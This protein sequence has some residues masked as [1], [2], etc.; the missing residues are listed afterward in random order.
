MGDFPEIGDA[1]ETAW[2]TQR[3]SFFLG[4]TNG[5]EE[6]SI[7]IQH[8]VKSRKCNEIASKYKHKGHTEYKFGAK[9]RIK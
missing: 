4:G 2:C 1:A 3:F 8:R 9:I 6:E 7:I 5:F